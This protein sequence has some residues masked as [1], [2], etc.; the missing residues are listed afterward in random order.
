LEAQKML[1]YLRETTKLK[2]ELE[3]FRIGISGP[4]GV[5]KVFDLI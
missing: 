4:P 2:S 5:G 3:T 1:N